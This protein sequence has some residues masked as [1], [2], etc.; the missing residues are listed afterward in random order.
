MLLRDYEIDGIF[1]PFTIILIL[2]SL[3]VMFLFHKYCRISFVLNK[4]LLINISFGALLIFF[5]DKISAFLESNSTDFL[6]GFGI[7]TGHLSLFVYIASALDLV[8][9]PIIFCLF[10]FFFLRFVLPEVK[11]FGE[12]IR[13]CFKQTYWLLSRIIVAT[14]LSVGILFLTIEIIDFLSGPIS[15]ISGLIWSSGEH[16]S[17]AAATFLAP[18]IAAIYFVILNVLVLVVA[19]QAYLRDGTGPEGSRSLELETP[20][21]DPSKPEY[22]LASQRT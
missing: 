20:E 14:T 4:K 7:G 2:K 5:S 9:N 19:S 11:K 15:N 16:K 3:T 6:I 22:G 8:L 1:R 10:L 21:H 17:N 12:I 13:D 18:V